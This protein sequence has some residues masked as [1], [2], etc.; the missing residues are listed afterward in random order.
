MK[1]ED[2]KLSLDYRV[3]TIADRLNITNKAT[4][5]IILEY[6]D[7]SRKRLLAGEII[8]F[9]GLAT[10]EPTPIYKAQTET[11][12][13][14]A[15]RIAKVLN[16]GNVTAYRVLREYLDSIE[17]DIRVGRPTG[18]YM[19]IK[20]KPL[21]RDGEVVKIHSAISTSISNIIQNGEAGVDKVR[22][23]THQLIKH[24]LKE[25]DVT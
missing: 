21:F 8:A 22:C 5:S 11:L 2:G 12:A 7:D 1:I 23:H 24:S 17:E 6:I 19:V 20:M 18:V 15:N 10:I 14:T 4:H 16:V 25:V 13:F 3:R 9:P